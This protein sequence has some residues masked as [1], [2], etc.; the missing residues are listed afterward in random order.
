MPLSERERVEL[1]TKI[2]EVVGEF[3]G[4]DSGAHVGLT[5]AFERFVNQSTAVLGLLGNL[6][7]A[8]GGVSI[9]I[10]KEW[11]NQEAV[12]AETAKPKNKGGR[13][14]KDKPDGGS[15]QGNGAASDKAMDNP[16]HGH[17]EDAQDAEV[18]ET[19]GD[20]FAD[21]NTTQATAAD[22]PATLTEPDVKNI[23]R[24]F[25]NTKGADG[26]AALTQLLMKTA[27]V[28]RFSEVP[29][30]KWLIVV[31]AAQAEMKP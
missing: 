5:V 2:A 27:G 6:L 20:P 29:A 31:R 1:V 3:D 25:M 15:A 28:K 24:E 19:M 7:A 18:T 16:H 23:L 9:P 30:A 10:P 21:P 12:N 13:P 11:V 4:E 17:H 26:T 22:E 14:K 8:Q